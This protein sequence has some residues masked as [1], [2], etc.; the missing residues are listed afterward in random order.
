MKKLSSD[1]QSLKKIFFSFFIFIFISKTL[2]SNEILFEIKGNDFT[3]REAILSLL[4]KIP[5]NYLKID[6]ILS[7]LPMLND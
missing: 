5:K 3:D 2:Y 6:S 7:L 4:D 1:Y